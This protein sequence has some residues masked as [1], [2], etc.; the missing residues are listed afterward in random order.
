MYIYFFFFYDYRIENRNKLTPAMLVKP[1]NDELKKLISQAVAS[2]QVVII[3]FFINYI[4]IYIYA[5]RI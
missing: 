1:N 4:Y 5:S 3:F 2:Y